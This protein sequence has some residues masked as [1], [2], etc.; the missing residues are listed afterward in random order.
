MMKQR[1]AVDVTAEVVVDVF[2]RGSGVPAALQRLE[3]RVTVEA[4]AAGDY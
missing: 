2:E 4:L 3:T 1:S